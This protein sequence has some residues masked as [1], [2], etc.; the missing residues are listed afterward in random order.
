MILAL[1][2][3]DVALPLIGGSV[4][5]SLTKWL[6]QESAKWIY[7]FNIQYL[8]ALMK[9]YIA[10]KP[11]LGRAIA[12]ALP[13]PCKK[14]EGYI[15]AAN[16]DVVSWCI[17]HLLEQADPDAYN[18]E[19]KRWSHEHL[20][21]IP[22]QW[23][24]QAKRK[25]AKQLGV[26]RKLVKQADSLVHAGDPD[27]EGQLLVDEVI[28]FLKVKGTKRDNAERLLISDLN[29]PAVTRALQQLRSN[30]DFIPL[31]T[32][33]LARSRADWLFGINLTRAYTLQGRK[34]GYDGVLSVGR[35]QTPLLGLVVRRDLAVEGFTSQDF[36]EVWALVS[37]Y[38]AGVNGEKVNEAL[39]DVKTIAGHPN[40]EHEKET[41]FWAK[42][43]PSDACSAQ[44]DEA[45]RNLSQP[46]AEHV[47]KR[48]SDKPA[49]VVSVERKKKRENAPLPHSLSSLQIEAGKVFGMSAKQA[50]DTCQTLYER[51][52]L[53]T[54]P[55]SDS[56]YLPLEHFALRKEVLGA[57]HANVQTASAGV[58]NETL[59]KQ[60]PLD[61]SL[62]SHAWNDAKVDAHHAIIPTA[63]SPA[64]LSLDEAKIY[65]LIARNYLG[66]FL[67]AHERWQT[68]IT[69]E[70]EQG[71]FVAR[72]NQLEC[73]GWK[74]LLPEKSSQARDDTSERFRNAQ[75]P[76][77]AAGDALTSG[78]A[79]VERKQTSP[80]K[81]FTDATLL[82]AMTGINKHVADP[83]L[84]KILKD[85]DGL[86]TEA[87]RAGIIELLFKRNFLSRQGKSVRSTAAGRAFI[88]A[89]PAVVT[90]PDMTARWESTMAAICE[91]QAKYDDLMNPVINQL[92]TLVAESVEVTP[93]ALAQLPKSRSSG[94]KWAKAK[95]TKTK[96]AQTSKTKPVPTNKSRS[97]G[98]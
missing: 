42:W 3:A 48:V 21:I 70:I 9:L 85:T 39:E 84:Q 26:L 97:T 16:G 98:H 43:Q 13:Q 12:D 22:Q 24:L 32:S 65:S 79:E 95:R 91:R 82:A 94:A 31:S 28:S 6:L 37:V 33:A 18:P 53:I 71:S 60:L 88:E 55:R 34:V 69:L 62:K 14:G 83:S 20:P 96:P 73:L 46:L 47:V 15:T 81:P 29:L 44:L 78:Q 59:L 86:G 10:E 38:G 27:R 66:Q 23:Q 50:L 19:Y 77:V 89:L 61:Q 30:R 76:S 36:F 92:Q 80:P 63:K 8:G 2:E 45:G 72:A 57:I 68:T 64:R 5:V 58:L 67:V 4:A 41:E 51:H 52:K 90:W 7:C 93:K 87:T 75:L 1:P 11:S 54:Y 56:R 40:A 25:T 49:H 17:G 35:V 74:L